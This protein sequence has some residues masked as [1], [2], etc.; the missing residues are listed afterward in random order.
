[1]FTSL[2]KNH[3]EHERL[4]LIQSYGLINKL[5][6]LISGELSTKALRLELNLL[7]LCFIKR[8][9]NKKDIMSDTADMTNLNIELLR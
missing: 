5:I 1:M 7:E 4:F 9:T 6:E 2:L 8:F 3:N